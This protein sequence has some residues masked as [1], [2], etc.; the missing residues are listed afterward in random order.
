MSDDRKIVS[1]PFDEALY[2]FDA[3]NNV[4]PQRTIAERIGEK[5]GIPAMHPIIDDIAHAIEDARDLG[6]RRA[7]FVRQ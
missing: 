3:A 4:E 2:A 5:Y 1:T 6:E 7:P